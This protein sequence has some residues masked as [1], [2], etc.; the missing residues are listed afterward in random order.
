MRSQAGLIRAAR[1]RLEETRSHLDRVEATIVDFEAIA[2]EL[3]AQI[4]SEEA[5]TGCDDPEYFAYSTF[6]RAARRRREKL[7][8]S[9]AGL[10]AELG[11]VRLVLSAAEE[12]AERLEHV[13][14]NESLVVSGGAGGVEDRSAE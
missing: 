5:R 13:R 7:A 9:I 12:E 14:P 4:L 10:K 2:A 11:R 6:A 8:A 1:F 3:D